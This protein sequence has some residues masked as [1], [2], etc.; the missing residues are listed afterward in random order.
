MLGSILLVISFVGTVIGVIQSYTSTADEKVFLVFTKIG[1][2]LVCLSCIGLVVGLKKEYNN[3][4]EKVENEKWKNK[5]LKQV[6]YIAAGYYGVAENIPDAKV[7][8][9]LSELTDFLVATAS[10]SRKSNFSM[11]DFSMSD[12]SMSNFS[13]C[14]LR[15][16]TF[17][18]AY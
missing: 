17:Q 12:F 18:I 14:Y 9:K 13:D 4:Q 15:E 2:I 5:M 7:A 11:S 3:Y 6:K 1:L 16:P 8:S 10:R